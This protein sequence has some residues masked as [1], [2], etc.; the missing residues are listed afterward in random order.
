M[1]RVNGLSILVLAM[2]MLAAAG[3]VTWADSDDDKSKRKSRKDPCEGVA[4]ELNTIYSCANSK[5]KIR[6]VDCQGQ[7]RPNESELAWNKLN[8]EGDF[9]TTGDIK[10]TGIIKSGNSIVINGDSFGGPGDVITATSGTLDFD[11]DNLITTGSVGIGVAAPGAK[12]HVRNGSVLFNGTLGTIP[13]EG[14]GA[15]MMWYPGKKAFRAGEVRVSGTEW[16]DVNVGEL[17]TVTGGGGQYCQ[18]R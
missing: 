17:S 3:V 12:L 15:R 7:C 4:M 16:D 10:T 8:A 1:R 2:L 5:G 11:N 13:V 14:P 9:I 18:R 6:V